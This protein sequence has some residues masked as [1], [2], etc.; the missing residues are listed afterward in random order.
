MTKDIFMRTKLSGGC[1]IP[2][3]YRKGCFLE[4]RGRCP[5]D[6]CSWHGI[7]ED[8]YPWLEKQLRFLGFNIPARQ[9]DVSLRPPGHR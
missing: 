4:W 3:P 2:S 9:I 7:D 5:E 8:V 1:L 6:V